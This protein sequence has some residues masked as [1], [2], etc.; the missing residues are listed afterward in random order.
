MA[1][2]GKVSHA[3][4]PMIIDGSDNEWTVAYAEGA[5]DIICSDGRSRVAAT[6][7]LS[8]PHR[9]RHAWMALSSRL[10]RIRNNRRAT[11]TSYINRT[12]SSARRGRVSGVVMPCSLSLNVAAD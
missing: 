12:N 2:T 8:I 10:H 3:K 5:V 6:T 1:A 7:A 11:R 9:P 4:H